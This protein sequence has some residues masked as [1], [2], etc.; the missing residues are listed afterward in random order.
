MNFWNKL[1]E[2]WCGEHYHIHIKNVKK[3]PDYKPNSHFINS[4]S[5]NIWMKSCCCDLIE[6][7]NNKEHSKTCIEK[8]N[9]IVCDQ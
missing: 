2:H 9:R 4:P 8:F 3:C 7:R 5:F 6:P 1:K